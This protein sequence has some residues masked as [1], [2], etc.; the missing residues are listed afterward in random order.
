MA[1]P[2]PAL[3]LGRTSRRE[4]ADRDGSGPE[5]IPTNLNIRVGVVDSDTDAAQAA[6][7]RRLPESQTLRFRVV[8]KLKLVDDDGPGAL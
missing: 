4:L 8:N 2:R 3:G 6:S 1:Q 7:L 5:T